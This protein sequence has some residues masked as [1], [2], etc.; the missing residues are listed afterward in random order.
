MHKKSV[1]TNLR[2]VQEEAARTFKLKPGQKVCQRCEKKC[3]EKTAAEESTS[4]S[5]GEF[6]PQEVAH[7]SLD[8]SVQL[9]GIS[10]L[11][12]KSERDKPGYAKR[13]AK[14]INTAAKSKIAEVLDIPT[15]ELTSSQDEGGCDRCKD[16]DRLVTLLKEKC[17][18]ATY[19][20]KI[21]IVTL[22]PESWTIQ[23]TV[24]EFS[25]TEHLVKKAR[26]LKKNKGIL[27]DPDSKAGRKL[28]EA[29]KARVTAF[30]Q[31]DEFSRMCPGK[32]EY[33]SVKIDGERQQMQ[34]RLLL[35]NI[36]EL[37][38]EYIKES[39]DKIGISKFYELRPQWCVP[40]TSSGMHSVCVCQHHQNTKLCCSVI[41]EITDYKELL[42][43]M[44]C[45]T[46]NRECMLHYCD[47]CPGKDGLVTYLTEL[48]ATNDIEPEDIITYKQW[49]LT[50]RTALVTLQL[51]VS[52]FIPQVCKQF[53][54]LRA[55]HFVAKAQSAFLRE[56]K[57]TLPH[58]S[59]IVLLDFAENYSFIVQDAVQGHHWDNSQATLHPFC[60]YV[61]GAS[62]NLVSISLCVISECLK[63]DTTTVH[64][65]IGKVL[66]HLKQTLPHLKKVLYFSDGAASQYKN[67]KNFSNLLH[68]QNDFNLEAEWHF[69][70]TS[71]RKSPCDEVSMGS[72]ELCL[73]KKFPVLHR[74]LHMV[75]SPN[76]EASDREFFV[77]TEVSMGSC[78]LC[79]SKKFPVL[80]RDLHTVKS[81]K[82]RDI[83]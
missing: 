20:E 60:I 3:A 6:E 70:A 45:S 59:A 10:P 4:Q 66:A 62:G 41:P 56:L 5:S 22:A 39:G 19:Q 82:S 83:S 75:K 38:S 69:F 27:A 48:F 31:N 53:N 14:D 8:Q 58:D 30:Y 61:K 42:S 9:L 71:H 79:P 57:D 44:V 25:V 47:N 46:E 50:D 15:E 72:C 65:F 63:H 17:A 29:V 13:K 35:V 24:E 73:S 67:Y 37:Y 64:A 23:R 2:V 11:K 34:K 21:K 26:E 55:H 40:V 78:K 18:T 77:S 16:L 43:K 51:P 74:D 76:Y 49:V 68:H 36:N 80:H 32:K 52:E 12:R 81:P 54:D 33:V 28:D 1:R 7:D